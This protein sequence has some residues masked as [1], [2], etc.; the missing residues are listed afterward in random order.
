MRRGIVCLGAFR[1]AG[2][3]PGFAYDQLVWVSPGLRTHG[4]DAAAAQAYF[5][6]LRERVD[7][8]PGVTQTSMAWLGPWD[9]M[10]VGASWQGHDFAG[11]Q[12]DPAF[13]PALGIDL[14]R[15]RHFSTGDTGV[16][17]VNEAAAQVLWPN[18]DPLG[19]T[20]PWG[21]AGQSIIGVARNA[22]TRDV[23]EPSSLEYYLPTAAAEVSDSVLI[24]RVSGTPRDFVRSLN[25]AA[26]GLDGRLQP[27]VYVASDTFDRAMANAAQAMA[28]I[29]GLGAIANLL[30]IVGLAGLA[31]YTVVQRAREIAVRIALG[32]RPVHVIGSLFAPMRTPLL[33]GFVFG[34]IGGAVGAVALRS[35]IPTMASLEVF[36]PLPYASAL[37]LF[38]AVVG[39][40]I[41]APSRRAVRIDPLQ[42]LKSE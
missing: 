10:H 11:N 42:A 38:A 18:Q 40:S 34:A 25:D 14:V 6:Q 19:K 32:A 28:A 30:S 22:S 17:I 3:D 31:G 26:R 5:D 35:S 23:G 21:P 7:A 24:V 16:V 9:A 4:Y 1:A 27:S 15:G 36:S 8:I 37:V 13:L 20:L 33:I 2:L 29:A 39:V 12:V 41:L